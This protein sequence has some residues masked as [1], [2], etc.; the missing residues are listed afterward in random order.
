LSPGYYRA[1]ALG[2]PG[3]LQGLEVETLGTVG[4]ELKVAIED[5]HFVGIVV[6]ASMISLVNEVD[7]FGDQWKLNIGTPN[8]EH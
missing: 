8:L 1:L 4:V 5:R 6:Q 3:F 7:V 2:F